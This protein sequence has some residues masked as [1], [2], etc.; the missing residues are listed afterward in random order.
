MTRHTYWRHRD[1]VE[2]LFPLL[3][4]SRPNPQ[5]RPQRRRPNRQLAPQ[6]RME[7]SCRAAPGVADHEKRQIE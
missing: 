7:C 6:C 5:R 4:R 2:G 1:V 3:L